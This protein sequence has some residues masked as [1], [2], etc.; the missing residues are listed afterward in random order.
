MRLAIPLLPL[1]KAADVLISQ[2]L[3][4]AGKNLMILKTD[5]IEGVVKGVGGGC[6][7]EAPPP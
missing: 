4:L 7:G 1:S 6:R 5:L 2:R 3:L